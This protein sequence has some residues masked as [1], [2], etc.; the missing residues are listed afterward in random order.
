MVKKSLFVGVFALMLVSGSVNAYTDIDG[1]WAQKE[2]TNLSLNGIVSGYDDNSFK[3]D[4]NMTRAE[5][6]TVINRLLGN[7]IENTKY[8]PDINAKDWFYSEIRKGI[9]SGVIKGD[10]NGYVR[11][12]DL[13][14]REEA[15]VMIQRAIVP[16]TSNAI[17]NN[18]SDFNEISEWSKRAITTFISENYIKGYEDNTIKPKNYITRAEVVKIIENIVDIY[19]TFGEFSGEVHGNI[20]VLGKNV[21]LKNISIDGDLIVAEGAYNTLK[22]ENIII[23]GNLVLRTD[24]NL[25]DKNF[26]LKGK[27]YNL[28]PIENQ[29]VSRYIND[30]YGI[31]FS[32]PEKATVIFI[33]DEKQK[34]NYK[35]KNL[36]TIRINKKEELYFTSFDSALTNERERFDVIYDEMNRGK[37]GIYK[38]AVYGSEKEDSYFVYLKRDDVEYSIY[39]YNIENINV[40]DSLVN[41]I[42]LYEGAKITPHYEKNYKNSDLYLKFSYLDYVTVDDSYNTKIVN[43][44]E[45]FFK[46][47]IQVTNII[48]MSEYSIE[49][50]EEILVSLEDSDAKIIE[51]EIKK[52]Y[53]Y[54]AIE[55]TVKNE[56]KLTK[57]LYV[58]I[59]TK[60]YHFI[61]VGE[62]DKMNSVGIEIYNDIINSIEF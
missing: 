61:F 16:I 28:K 39:F 3:P 57:S 12:N 59:S 4:K 25:P 18:Y 50:L 29:N 49:E 62:E 31:S 40:I 32:T 20:L 22:L 37:I 56:E 17:M 60:L 43:E 26:V 6:T 15:I 58:V 24:V 53:T 44:E 33:Q 38:Y 36:M 7:S 45:A 41:S 47:F 46:M 5:L 8:V 21:T 52:V 2:I 51:S 19:A 1:H 14:T 9:E 54:D 13:V 30:D 23:E 10:A 34:I 55:Y 42:K 11:P 35:T 27:T 48:D